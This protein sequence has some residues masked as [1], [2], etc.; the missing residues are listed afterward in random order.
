[1]GRPTFIYGENPAAAT[2]TATDS[3]ANS[4]PGNVLHPGEDSHWA[5]LNQTGAKSV[6]ID[7]GSARP[8]DSIAF[9]GEY[10]DGTT[11]EVRGS[12]DNFVASDVQVSPPAA[13]SA[14]IN[15]AWRA[16][17]SSSYRYVKY[18]F[19]TFSSALKVCGILATV[20]PSLPALK[21][22]V[23]EYAVDVTLKTQMSEAGFYSGSVRA[24]T[25]QPLGLDFG[26]VQNAEFADLGAWILD[27]AGAGLPL[28]LVPDVDQAGV[29]F[30]WLERVRLRAPWLDVRNTARKVSPFTVMTRRS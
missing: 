9:L 3:A 1:M 15:A 29:Y 26:I 5:P 4:A 30:C 7:Y 10:L 14:G 11:V 16:V 17:A 24:R 13:L 25:L 27:G 8:F 2:V 28:F 23:D 18:I 20:K 6:V 22:A 12:T 19:T 21:L